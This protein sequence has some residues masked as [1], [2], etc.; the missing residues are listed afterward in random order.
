MSLQFQR[1][2]LTVKRVIIRTMELRRLRLLHE[3]SRRG[4]VAAFG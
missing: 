2:F 3:F 1:W 4:T